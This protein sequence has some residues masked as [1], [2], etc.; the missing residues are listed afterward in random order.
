M[1]LF[2]RNGVYWLVFNEPVKLDFSNLSGPYKFLLVRKQQIPHPTATIARLTV[3]EGYTPSV[4]RTENE[5]KIDF[6]IGEAPRITNSIDIQPQP[7]SAQGARVFIPAVN[8]GNRITFTDPEAGD[9]LISVPLY[10]P[11]WGLGARRTFAQFVVLPSMQ[12]IGMYTRDSSVNVAVE[13]NG[14]SVTADEGLQLVREISRDDLFAGGDETDKFG[15]KQ[16]TAQLVK[17]NE[18][19]QVT[20]REFWER[21]QLLQ[22]RVAKA[23]Q[24]SRN[25]ARLG[26]AKY[27]VA[28][29]FYADA[30]GVLERD[31]KR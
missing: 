14:V 1:A 10:A 4:A 27:F 17:L 31:P 2:E 16:D 26:L 3:R 6:R 28:H 24:G 21:K 11:S 5:W 12:G 9:E 18:W 29:K 23:P 25:A 19:A 22:Q 8:N 20:P 7:A 15:Q 30:Y 13:R